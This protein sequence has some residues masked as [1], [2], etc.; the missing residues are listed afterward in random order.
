MS[1]EEW[2]SPHADVPSA[3]GAE[4]AETPALADELSRVRRE[5]SR[6]QAELRELGTPVL[7]VFDGVLVM[8][9]IGHL[10]AAR[11][12]H[13]MD[14]LLLSVERHEAT[15]V[16]VD[17][18]GVSLVD[19][20]VANLLIQTM[21]AVGFLGAECVLAGVS[22]AVSRTMVQLGIQLGAMSSFRNLQDAMRHALALR[23]QEI[24]QKT[25]PVDWLE[26]LA[27]AVSGEGAA[28]DVAAAESPPDVGPIVS[29]DAELA[30]PPAECAADRG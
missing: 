27:P 19:T 6:L 1:G 26:E 2:K 13:L 7:P 11:G 9:L 3:E 8:P 30:S 18:T 21:R 20:S 15:V 14:D 28:L 22:A 5:L 4:A 29:S 12:T 10:D 17:I 16:I 25:A 23:G 24:V